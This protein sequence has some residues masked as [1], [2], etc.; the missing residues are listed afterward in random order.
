MLLANIA[1]S[2]NL[3]GLIAAAGK[4]EFYAAAKGSVHEPRSYLRNP[5]RPWPVA[6]ASEFD[7]AAG[8]F[9][10]IAFAE[11]LVGEACN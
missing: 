6:A 2:H 11:R 5:R 7:E 10:A 4:F 8:Q 1:N 9:S 3:A